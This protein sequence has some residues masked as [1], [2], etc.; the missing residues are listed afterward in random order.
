MTVA[1]FRFGLQVVTAGS[2][3]ALVERA[4][5]VEDLGFEV[6]QT[7][8]HLD[9][10]LPPLVTLATVAE[11]TT[12][13]RVGTLVLNNDLRH[14]VVLARE[15]AAVDLLSEGR[16]ELGIGAGHSEPEYRSAGLRFDPP[17]VR[18][19][20]LAESLHL[21]DGLLR[22]E[23]VTSAGP[24]YA[25]TAARAFPRPVQDPRPPLLVGGG[26]RR[27]LALAAR[28]ADVVGLTGTG[29]T[30]ADGRD[31][32]PSHWAPSAVDAQVAHVRAEAAAAGR[33]AAPE[34]HALVQVVTVTGDRRRALEAVQR[35][36][37]ELTLED[38]EGTPYL[39]VGT[40]DAMVEQLQAARER[41]G[42]S[43]V[44]VRDE[45]LAPAVARLAGT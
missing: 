29:P 15:A 39:L 25:V 20:R 37:P 2:R 16:L 18:I 26:G 36:L 44:T 27:L 10:V 42:I 13:L 41:W 31:H 14:P 7:A 4:R 17:G 43:Y 22:G 30:R 3:G 21:L 5:R 8:D 38:L 32:V 19:D 34:L 11:A 12:T 24:H 9:E 40:V 23:E 1:P 35:H 33:P 28:T 45:A 6:L